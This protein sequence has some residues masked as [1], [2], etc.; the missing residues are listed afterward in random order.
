[1]LAADFISLALE[2]NSE[3]QFALFARRPAQIQ[4]ALRVRGIEQSPPCISL[5]EFSSD[6]W[7]A[8]VNF[9]GVG[10]PAHAAGMRADILRITLDWD[11]RVLDYINKNPACRY[12]FMSSGAAFGTSASDV[13]TADT[14]AH[15]AVND[16]TSSSFYGI[17]KFYSEATHRAHPDQ[18]I[19]D[20][21]I[22][23]YLSKFADLKHR[24]FINEV[25]A[26]VRD[27]RCLEVVPGDMQRDYLGREDFA[28]LL[29]VCLRAPAGYNG[30]IDAYSLAPTSKSEILDLFKRRFG[31]SYDVTG[32]ALNATGIKSRYFSKNHAAAMLGY[33]PRSS[34][35]QTVE[36]VARDILI[37]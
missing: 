1:M 18:S 23:N 11:R 13:I 26:A 21:R 9:I 22:F 4:D 12:I 20:I 7:D 31:L 16:L 24:F 28:S 14:Q 2:R 5:D 36:R 35:L 27:S 3:A 37:S 30:A 8:I 25:I 32:D 33:E 29:G 6:T 17:A 19:I 34:S 10:D 15:F